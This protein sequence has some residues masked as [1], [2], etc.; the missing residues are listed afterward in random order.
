MMEIKEEATL[1]MVAVVAILL[2]G[3]AAGIGYGLGLKEGV[4]RG[5]SER[6]KEM[7]SEG[8][9]YCCAPQRG[10]PCAHECEVCGE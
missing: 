7:L 6:Y 5:R 1:L 2:L 3:V 8:W 9:H 10:Q 4:A